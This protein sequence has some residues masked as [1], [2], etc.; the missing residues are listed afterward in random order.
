MVNAKEQGTQQITYE[1][2]HP[3]HCTKRVWRT[4]RPVPMLQEATC[5]KISRN[6]HKKHA[7]SRVVRR[8][9]TAISA[10]TKYE[11]Q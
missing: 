7:Q 5:P 4:E 11:A 1:L 8:R 10:S 3:K 9:R 2:L 6:S